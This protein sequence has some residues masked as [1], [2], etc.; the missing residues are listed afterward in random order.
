MRLLFFIVLASLLLAGC[1]KDTDT[2]DAQA[3]KDVVQAEMPE[4]PVN[5]KNDVVKDLPKM[6]QAPAE[7]VTAPDVTAQPETAA[8]QAT[9]PIEKAEVV[10][11]ADV[12]MIDVPKQ[13]DSTE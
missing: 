10:Q 12:T 1:K 13:G 6:D 7:V 4:K 9:Q 3:T 2:Q 5:V 11:A 8:D